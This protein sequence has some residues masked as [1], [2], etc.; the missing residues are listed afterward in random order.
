MV[1]NEMMTYKA[2][3]V[4]GNYRRMGVFLVALVAATLTACGGGQEDGL[5][6]AVADFPIAYVKR[7][8]PVDEETGMLPVNDI[9]DILAFNPGADLYLRERASPTAKEINITG[10]VTR[11]R[12]DVKDVSVSFDGTKLL[13][14]LRLPEIEDAEPEDQPSWNIWQYDIAEKR[15]SRLIES[16]IAAE[17]GEDVAPHFLTDGGIVFTSTRQRQSKKILLQ[18]GKPQFTAL[19]E[20]RNAAAMTLHV[21]SGSGDNIEQ[22]T[23]NQSLDFDPVVLSSGEIVFSRWDNVANRSAINLYKV[24]P[25][26]S[27][28]EILYGAH[29][30]DGEGEDEA[31]I[32]QYVKPKEFPDGRLMAV[33][34]S[35]ESQLGDK[36]VLIDTANFADATQLVAGGDGTQALEEATRYQVNMA[37][38]VSPGGRFG[39]ITPL[40]DGTQRALISWSSC[41]VM[42]AGRAVP[43]NGANLAQPEPVEA[44]PAYG[45][46]IYD[47]QQDTQLPVV[48]PRSGTVYTDLVAA[49]PRNFQYYTPEVNDELAAE[50]VGLLHIRS[51]YDLDGLADFDLDGATDDVANLGGVDVTTLAQLADPAVVPAEARRA[52]FLRIVKAVGIPDDDIVEIANGDF[53]RSRNQLMREIVGYAMVEPDGSVM[54]KVPANVALMISV[55][56]ADGRR[57]GDRHN[58]WIQVRPG[59]VRQCNG[60]HDHASGMPHGRRGAVAALNSGAPTSGLPFSNTNPLWNA[61]M[62]ETM[63]QTRLNNECSGGWAQADCAMLSPG[64]DLVFEDVWPDETA[65]ARAAP[66]SYRYADLTTPRPGSAECSPNWS[67]QCRVV[68]N[69][70]EHIHP[71]W[72]ASRQIPNAL[73]AMVEGNCV[74]CHT[75]NNGAEFV[76]PAGQL[77]LSDDVFGDDIRRRAY[78][79]L[80]NR[81]NK[82][83][84][85]NGVLVDV[86]VDELV[87][88]VI[89]VERQATDADGNLLFEVDADGN[90]VLDEN[91]DPVP[92]LEIV[93][94][95]IQVTIQVPV[96]VR[97]SMSTNAARNSFFLRRMSGTAASRVDPAEE[98]AVDHTGMLTAAEL[99]LISEWADIGGQYYNDP[100]DIPN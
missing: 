32:Y 82:Q 85:V 17:S 39:A 54:A 25:D 47:F 30:H 21:M 63:A 78:N 44:P 56:D 57:I 97:Q 34:R 28:L 3:N 61:E 27:G 94:E 70:P 5:D 24:N 51:V 58:N 49:R 93:Q 62:G 73:G 20:D 6:P 14:A 19:D 40:W 35:Q 68:I 43:C 96:P 37:D 11:G 69:Y 4:A 86:L 50:A 7:P 65:A 2:E 60:C 48:L 89:D 18:E 76:V 41:R 45:I 1:M 52:R 42:A 84:L 77:D 12:G 83:E 81:D 72:T 91:G 38:G 87:D 46:Y 92:V 59:E 95:T 67:A 99:K 64:I 31:G 53:G 29:S 98:A 15:L 23:F 10:A 9:R 26:G 75:S 74:T 16:D 88:Q 66:F 71:L 33:I 13:F 22:I 100:F 36:M 55:L 79:E 8:V 90:P 80:F